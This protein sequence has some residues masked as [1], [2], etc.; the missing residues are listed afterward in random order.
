MDELQVDDRIV[1]RLA[2]STIFVCEL[3]SL[4]T[5]KCRQMFIGVYKKVHEIL[6]FY[7]EERSMSIV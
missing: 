2:V 4:K 7:L 5:T 1:Q 6:P 3:G